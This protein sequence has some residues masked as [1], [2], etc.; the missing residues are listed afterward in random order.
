MI[1]LAEDYLKFFPII[2]AICAGSLWYLKR[3]MM[4]GF[5]GLTFV[6]VIKTRKSELNQS[7]LNR[8]IIVAV[9]FGIFCLFYL[10]IRFIYL[11]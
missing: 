4:R 10:G 1:S 6:E 11:A 9:I 2:A 7:L 5:P 3:E 8:Y